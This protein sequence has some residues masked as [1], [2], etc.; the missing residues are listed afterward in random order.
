MPPITVPMTTT[1]SI[2]ETVLSAS[3]EPSTSCCGVGDEMVTCCEFIMLADPEATPALKEKVFQEKERAEDLQIM[4]HRLEHK[5]QQRERQEFSELDMCVGFC[6]CE[7]PEKLTMEQSKADPPTPVDAPSVAG[8]LLIGDGSVVSPILVDE[9]DDGIHDDP[10]G[11]N[12]ERGGDAPPDTTI[13]KEVDI[14]AECYHQQGGPFGAA[15]P[16][17]MT[18]LTGRSTTNQRH[19]STTHRRRYHHYYNEPER[20]RRRH[21]S[22]SRHRRHSS[23]SSV[24]SPTPSDHSQQRSL[25]DSYT[26]SDDP[27]DCELLSPE[28]AE[29]LVDIDDTSD[30]RE[31]Q[32]RNRSYYR[33][34]IDN[35]NQ[36]VAERTR[37]ARV[38]AG[39]GGPEYQRNNSDNHNSKERGVSSKLLERGALGYEREQE[40]Y[41]QKIGSTGNAKPKYQSHSNTSKE[42]RHNNRDDQVRKHN[43][44]TPPTSVY[45]HNP[46]VAAQSA[47]VYIESRHDLS[48]KRSHNRNTKSKTKRDSDTV[49][50]CAG[51]PPTEKGSKGSRNEESSISDVDTD[52]SSMTNKVMIVVVVSFCEFQSFR[53]GNFSHLRASPLSRCFSGGPKW[54]RLNS[55]TS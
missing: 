30:S 31:P 16:R 5:P 29:P 55:E 10:P 11:T 23:S 21:V 53:E 7:D 18:T 8:T 51:G 22:S 9:F 45:N 25:A 41:H 19:A 1:N 33:S 32:H 6:S 39:A 3:E 2:V 49:Q 37:V 36:I 26:L 52:R 38:E 34:S 54:T 48:P 4:K 20:H 27:D 12:R 46:V 24:P 15:H 43:Q 35:Q 47:R 28:E 14:D 44:G 50:A 40:R 17:S 13:D 42:R